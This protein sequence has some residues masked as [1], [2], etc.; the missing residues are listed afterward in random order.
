MSA[1]RIPALVLAALLLM[2]PAPVRAAEEEVPLIP[3]AAQ[4]GIEALVA[5]TE[6]PA[7]TFDPAS[8][9]PLVDFVAQEQGS[10]ETLSPGRRDGLQGGCYR[11]GIK[12]PLAKVLRYAY[13]PGIPFYVLSPSSVRVCGWSKGQDLRFGGKSAWEALASL[14]QPASA[15]GVEYE[16]GTPDSNSGAYFRYDLNRLLLLFKQNG[17][18]V[19][20]SVSKQQGP[21]GVGKKGVILDEANWDYFYSGVNGLT[22]PGLTWMDAYVYDSTSVQVFYE[23]EPGQPLT[24]NGVF[25]WCKG[26]W[27]KLNVIRREHVTGGL[28]RYMTV[29]KQLLESDRLPAPEQLAAKVKEIEALPADRLKAAVAGYSEALKAR[30]GLHPYMANADIA[31]VLNQGRYPEVQDREAA[32][33]LLVKDYL[34]CKLGKPMYFDSS[35]CQPQVAQRG[36]DQATN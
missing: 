36:E 32:V 25:K 30:T 1:I 29:F 14:D 35:L 10:M 22:K 33:S 18:N 7:K 26:G 23:P 24:V 11:A 16:E 5:L 3:K 34:R 2:L 27:M 13:N 15:R 12:A 28:K 31:E 9:A 19:F 4:A 20:I 21:S 8:V 17:R 6:D